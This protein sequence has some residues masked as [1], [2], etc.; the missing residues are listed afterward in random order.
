MGYKEMKSDSCC[1]Y[2]CNEVKKPSLKNVQAKEYLGHFSQD[3]YVAKGHNESGK[4]DYPGFYGG[5]RSQ[6]SK[7]ID[8]K[9]EEKLTQKKLGEQ[10]EDFSRQ[11]AKD[12]FY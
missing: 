1:D 10:W 12:R 6:I 2:M 7:D 3:K 8:K 11:P 5:D 9:I 4:M